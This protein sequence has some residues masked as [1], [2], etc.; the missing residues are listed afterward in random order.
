MSLHLIHLF[1]IQENFSNLLNKINDSV[2]KRENSARVLTVFTGDLYRAFKR[3]SYLRRG[4]K[5]LPYSPRVHCAYYKNKLIPTFM[6]KFL[7]VG[8]QSVKINRLINFKVK[9]WA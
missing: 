2:T 1:I 3:S 5:T 4:D 7:T 8:F 9:T 6:R